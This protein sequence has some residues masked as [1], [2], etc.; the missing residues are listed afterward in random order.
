MFDA[1]LASFQ[2]NDNF[3]DFIRCTSS[4]HGTSGFWFYKYDNDVYGVCPKFAVN[5]VK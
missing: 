3:T 1:G 5:Y 4:L 2:L